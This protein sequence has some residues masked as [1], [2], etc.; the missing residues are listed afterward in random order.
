MKKDFVSHNKEQIMSQVYLL[1]GSNLGN[2]PYFLSKAI[3]SINKYIGTVQKRSQV[4]E[5]EPWGFE[6]PTMFLNMVILVKTQL[7]PYQVLDHML[8]IESEI[9]RQRDE[10]N[11]YEAR[12]IDIDILFYDSMILKDTKLTIPHPKLHERK[13]TLVPLSEIAPNLNHPVLQKTIRQLLAECNDKNN[14]ELFHV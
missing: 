11:G 13:F 7:E 3:L 14:V 5:T 2:R 12:S 6:H 4:Y 9:G 10:S 1:L 8:S